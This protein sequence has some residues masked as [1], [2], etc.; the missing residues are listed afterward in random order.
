MLRRD[1]L[2]ETLLRK[3]AEMESHDFDCSEQVK[4]LRS[5]TVLV[6]AD[7]DSLNT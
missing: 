3:I 2:W 5:P 4:Q 6:F 1:F 7:A